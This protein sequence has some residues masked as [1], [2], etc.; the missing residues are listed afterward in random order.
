MS[1]TSSS[2]SERFFSRPWIQASLPWVFPVFVLAAWQVSSQAGWLST[3]VLPEPWAVVKAFWALTVSGEIWTHVAT[4]TWRALVGFAIGGGLGLALG[5]VTG[6]FRSAETLLDSTLQMI[7]NIPALALIPLVILWFGIDETAK[8]FL[9]ALGVFFP[10][11]LNTFHG[12]R[13]VDKGLIEMARSYGLSGWPLYRQVILPGAMASILVGVRFSLGLM[14]V[15]L[16]VA[17]T[18]S[19]QAGIGY[20]TMNAREFLQTDVVLVGILLYALLGKLAD[21]AA[22]GLERWWLRWHPGYQPQPRT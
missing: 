8:L 12:I 9:V 20:M 6:T 14:W 17:E 7:R 2:P 18:I 15:L 16:I 1:R 19:A 5:L 4:S 22:K 10:V 11:Y 3:R 13:S 21:V